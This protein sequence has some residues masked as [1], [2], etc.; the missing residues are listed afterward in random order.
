[1]ST[2]SLNYESHVVATS[3]L[4]VACDKC[5]LNTDDRFDVIQLVTMAV[6]VLMLLPRVCYANVTRE[7]LVQQQLFRAFQ[8]AIVFAGC[9][10]RLHEFC[11]YFRISVLTVLIIH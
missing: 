11:V 4:Q 9:S 10:C 3:V 8:G 1:M 6:K 7:H 5:A 2:G